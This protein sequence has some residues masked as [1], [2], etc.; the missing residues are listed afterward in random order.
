VQEAFG[1]H[2][3]ML[4]T[5][6]FS[7]LS[8][9][10]A[11]GEIVLLC[12][13][14]GAGKTTLLSVLR[15]ALTGARTTIPGMQGDITVS[16]QTQV[17][18]LEPLPNNVPLISALGAHCSIDDA[19]Y[20]LSLSGLAEAQLYVKRF[21]DLSNGQRYRAMMAKLLASRASVWLADEFC[22][23]LDPVTSNIVARNLRRSAETLH[24]S[25]IVA[26][27]NWSEF[28]EELRPDLIIHL[29]SPWEFR[30]FRWKDFRVAIKRSKLTI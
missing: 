12:G 14:S 30:V 6:L 15:R 10:V 29:R 5:T 24:A 19:L 21:C 7:N 18:T 20:A 22:A 8:F 4:S 25:A 16:K 23:T 2:K 1:I 26:A 3:E 27:A 9:K 28:I 13:P 17:A 11:P